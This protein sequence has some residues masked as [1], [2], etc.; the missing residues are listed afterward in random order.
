MTTV[1]FRTFPSLPKETLYPLAVTSHFPHSA[2]QPRATT[3]LCSLSIGCL[4]WL[5]NVNE[6]VQ[7]LVFWDWLP[8]YDFVLCGVRTLRLGNW[9]CCERQWLVKA[10]D[11]R[12]EGE[13]PNRFLS[14]SCA[15]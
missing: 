12:R 3:N 2:S 8:K 9:A 13:I 14:Q 4:F 11:V 10:V 7:Y 1:N 15:E 5:F 6:F